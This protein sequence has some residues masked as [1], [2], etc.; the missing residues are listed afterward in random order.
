MAILLTGAA[1]FVGFHTARRLLADGHTV[2]GRNTRMPFA[3]TNA[4]D[5]PL[6]LY[7]ATKRANELMAHAYSHLFGLPTSGLRFFTVYGP[8]GR[9]DMVFFL[10]TR[11]IL[12]GRPLDVY[13]FGAMQRDFTYVDDVVEAIVRVLE[14]VPAPDPAGYAGAGAALGPAESAAPYRVYNVGNQEPARLMDVI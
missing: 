14:V 4:A 8:W 11:A 5:H 9:P 3:E 1:G 10:F 2:Y 12:A 7:G 13:N 6:T